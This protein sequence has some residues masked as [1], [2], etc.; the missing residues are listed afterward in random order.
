IGA[1]RRRWTPAWALAA[2]AT[3]AC[4][5]FYFVAHPRSAPGAVAEKKLAVPQL[6][7]TV[8]CRTGVA[9]LQVGDEHT[10]AE[11]NA[12][13]VSGGVMAAQPGAKVIARWGGARVVVDGGTA[14]AKV[15][16]ETSRAE[17]RALRLESGR[18]VLDVDPMAQGET[19][20]IVT[21]DARVTVH[22]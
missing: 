8:L 14:G 2:C 1:P 4:V 9:D 20:A 11:A 19:L 13:W 18:V 16:L 12:G 15:K 10:T 22:G 3:A 7:M 5:A 21:E 17:E 6:P